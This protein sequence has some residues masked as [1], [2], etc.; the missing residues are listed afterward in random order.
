M[1]RLPYQ[2]LIYIRRRP[3][4]D[5]AEYLLL[6]RTATRGGF[7]QGVT[8]AVEGQESLAQAASRE[9]GEE[10]GYQRF[11]RFLALDFRYHYPLDREQWGH[12]Y[13]A[14]VETISEECF[15]A[16]VGLDQGE[17]MLDPSEHDQYR[18]LGVQDALALLAWPE[19]R[20]ALRH[21]ADTP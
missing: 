3:T 21:F 6:R 10:T 18:W 1:P 8:G 20:A 4:P 15:G 16:E 9:V 19:N 7:W 11:S 13:A 5:V 2:V 17:P 12:L 14:E